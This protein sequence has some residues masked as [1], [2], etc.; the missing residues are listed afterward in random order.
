MALVDFAGMTATM[1]KAAD[2]YY[3]ALRSS[4]RNVNPVVNTPQANVSISSS[5]NSSGETRSFK[6]VSSRKYN[7]CQLMYMLR[8]LS[9]SATQTREEQFYS[10]Q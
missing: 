5:H 1:W 8:P 10:D 9:H 2:K 3:L 4:A 7:I 6:E